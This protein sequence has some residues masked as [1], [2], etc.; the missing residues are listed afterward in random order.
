MDTRLVLNNR[1]IVPAIID[2]RGLFMLSALIMPCDLP[3][4]SMV[5]DFALFVMKGRSLVNR[6]R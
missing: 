5:R 4:Y 3:G 1:Q 6:A 2:T